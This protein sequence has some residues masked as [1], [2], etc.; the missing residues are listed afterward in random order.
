MI[1]TQHSPKNE[2]VTWINMGKVDIAQRWRSCRTRPLVNGQLRWDMY[3]WA[4]S[5]Q[6]P[7]LFFL[8]T[9]G[10]ADLW[11]LLSHSLYCL[12]LAYGYVPRWSAHTS[13]LRDSLCPSFL[14]VSIPPSITSGCETI[15]K[16]ILH[17]MATLSHQTLIRYHFENTE[18]E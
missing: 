14:L 3:F 5:T 10:S 4:F 9:S 16:L 6:S 15:S 13:V 12:G 17:Y 11:S 7:P 2:R 1:H 18:P 8:E